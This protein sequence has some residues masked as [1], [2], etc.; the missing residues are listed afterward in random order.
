MEDER[1]TLN[2]LRHSVYLNWMEFVLCERYKKVKPGKL[3]HYMFPRHEVDC[4]SSTY[5][6]AEIAEILAYRDLEK[7]GVS[8][9]LW[10][11]LLKDHVDYEPAFC[12][13][14][15]LEKYGIVVL[16]L[17]LECNCCRYRALSVFMKKL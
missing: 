11:K 7:N 10:Q 4:E 1:E 17:M 12:R 14:E 13:G 5:L 6:Q 9:T 2:I 16:C 15:R 8:G 3:S